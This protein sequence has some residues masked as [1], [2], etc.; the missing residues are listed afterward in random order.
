MSNLE[1]YIHG[2]YKAATRYYNLGGLF[3]VMIPILFLGSFIVSRF[4]NP[5]LFFI[6]CLLAALCF[7]GTWVSYAKA[8]RMTQ[9]YELFVQHKKMEN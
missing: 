2:T 4:L 3:L 6:Y 5:Q 7:I 8:E 9:K 1:T